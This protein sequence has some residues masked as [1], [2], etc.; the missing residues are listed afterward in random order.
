MLRSARSRHGHH[1]VPVG[2]KGRQGKALAQH[3]GVL[4]RHP[5]QLP[6]GRILF[7]D[8][9]AVPG[10]KD[11][12]R[13]SPADAL[14][15]ADLLGD[16]HPAQLVDAADDSSCFHGFHFLAFQPRGAQAPRFC[17]VWVLCGKQAGIIR[18]SILII[19]SFIVP[20]CRA[21]GL[22]PRTSA[23]RPGCGCLLPP[24]CPPGKGRC[25]SWC[26]CAAPAR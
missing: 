21:Y 16:D 10:G 1:P 14:G 6:D 20:V 25:R 17:T 24:C 22:Y 19:M 12:Q 18:P 3:L 5:L 15:A 11:L 9:L 2:H 4:H 13:V 8:D 23:G 26:R 7:K